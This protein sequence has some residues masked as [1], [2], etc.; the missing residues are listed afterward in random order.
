MKALIVDDER[1]ARSELRRLL[2]DFPD[3][4]IAGEA[5]H[6]AEAEERARALAPELIFLDIE[7]PGGSGFDLLE[8]LED[9]PAV[10]FTTAYDA[11]A[12]KAFQVNALDY[13]LKP[14]EPSRL[15]AALEKVRS[16]AA[17]RARG[18][19]LERVFVRDG[20]LCLLVELAEVKLFESEGNYAR[21]HLDGKQP[22]LLRSLNYL[23][24][25]LDPERFVRA[26]RQQL[27]NLR[28]VDRIEPGP[29]GNLVLTLKTGR[30]VEMSRRQ[31]LKF[32]RQME[33]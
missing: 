10:I 16:R 20:E 26:N 32:R 27:V 15:A 3:V 13:L 14:I 4:E 1:L 19:A 6:V 17:V 21:L 7:M 24:E 9:V 8:R 33:P 18:P 23:E 2:R 22:L 5:S 12:V 30:E 31:S 11:Y 29:S 28:W 25:K